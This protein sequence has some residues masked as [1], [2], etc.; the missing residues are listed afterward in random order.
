MRTV[1]SDT[2]D[3][4]LCKGP[5]GSL[6]EVQI[7]R[8]ILGQASGQNFSNLLSRRVLCCTTTTCCFDAQ[9]HIQSYLVLTLRII[10]T[11]FHSR[12]IKYDLTK[13]RVPLLRQDLAIIEGESHCVDYLL[14]V[15]SLFG[16]CFACLSL[17]HSLTHS[18]AKGYYSRV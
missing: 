7:S 1:H 2:I 6:V 9:D 8:G 16:D 17:S 18:Q 13:R 11:W 15:C 14:F 12:L 10:M 3:S 4:Q 5:A